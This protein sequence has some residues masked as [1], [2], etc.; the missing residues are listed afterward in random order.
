MLFLSALLWGSSPATAAAIEGGAPLWAQHVTASQ[1][2]SIWTNKAQLED[3]AMHPDLPQ[4]QTHPWALQ[5]RWHLTPNVQG[6]PVGTEFVMIEMGS[7]PFCGTDACN[8]TIVLFGLST[9]HGSDTQLH[10][11]KSNATARLV[12]A[13]HS[14]ATNTGPLI[15][16]DEMKADSVALVY[17]YYPGNSSFYG[18][19][20]GAYP[21]GSRIEVCELI[22]HNLVAPLETFYT[23]QGQKETEYTTPLRYHHSDPDN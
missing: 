2:V 10:S 9:V 15:R 5:T 11:Y 14:N 3:E 21:D 7:T 17:K 6:A 20:G 1:R 8:D 12:K 18:V 22:A 19:G 23:A 16:F 13:L 4:D